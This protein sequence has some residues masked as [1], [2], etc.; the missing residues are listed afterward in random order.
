LEKASR[1]MHSYT[2][3]SLP[4]TTNDNRVTGFELWRGVSQL[5]HTTPVVCILTTKSVNPKTGNMCQT[6][7]LRQDMPPHEAVNQN[8]DT[9]ICGSCIHR[10]LR[11]CYV[12][13]WQAPRT[14]WETWKEEK[15]PTTINQD[16]SERGLRIGAYGDP[17]AVPIEVWDEVI[18]KFEFAIGYTHQWQHDVRLSRYCMASVDSVEE[19]VQANAAGFRTFR[20]LS[21][22]EKR[23]RHHEAQC[24][25]SEEAGHLMTCLQCRY[26]EVGNVAIQIH[27]PRKNLWKPTSA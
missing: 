17:A 2:V 22:T 9:P 6:W 14:I 3:S 11:T 15:Y 27:G 23:I 1:G 12:N 21:K 19:M 8:K 20:V 18:P 4:S 25:A 5:D 13:V 16:F 24:P 26:C 7:I 10:A